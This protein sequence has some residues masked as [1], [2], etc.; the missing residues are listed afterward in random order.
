[1]AGI[2]G[3]VG[4]AG[5]VFLTDRVVKEVFGWLAGPGLEWG[6][7]MLSPVD[8]VDEDDWPDW[9]CL[10]VTPVAAVLYDSAFWMSCW[11]I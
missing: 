5:G 6:R 1:M 3:V 7:M 4:G 8:P 2:V 9:G 11:D 10:L